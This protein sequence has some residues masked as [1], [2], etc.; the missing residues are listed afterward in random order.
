MFLDSRQED[1]KV[2][3][4]HRTVTK[5]K[6]FSTSPHL[7]D[8]DRWEDNIKMNLKYIGYEGVDW[9]HVDQDKDQWSSGEHSMNLRTV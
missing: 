8:L 1:K 9:I 3:E 6:A 5:F 4:L 2:S 7:G